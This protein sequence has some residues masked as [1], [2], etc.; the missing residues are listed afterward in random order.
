M[1]Q[2]KFSTEDLSETAPNVRLLAGHSEQSWS[3][4]RQDV[5]GVP[6]WKENPADSHA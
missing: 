6:V 4:P 1:V 5:R 2:T 3:P